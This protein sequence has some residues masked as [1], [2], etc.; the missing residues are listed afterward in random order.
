MVCHVNSME[1]STAG[2]LNPRSISY[3]H[4]LVLVRVFWAYFPS[5]ESSNLQ[6]RSFGFSKATPFRVWGGPEKDR[7]ICVF[8]VRPSRSFSPDSSHQL[9]VFWHDGD[10]LGMDGTQVGIIK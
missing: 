7:D 4:I 9:D 5:M 10:S 3:S 8:V 6:H 2:I 1:A